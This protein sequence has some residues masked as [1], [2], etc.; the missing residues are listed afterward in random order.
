VRIANAG[1]VQPFLYSQ[2]SCQ[3]IKL[4]G[5][6]LG[7]FDDVSYEEVRL[8]LEPGNILVFYSDGIDDTTDS[9][10]VYF[11]SDRV[12][13]LVNKNFAL[14]SAEIAERILEAVDTFSGGAHAFDDRTLV[15]LKVL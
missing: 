11:G 3:Q 10:G 7:M 2:G 12:C 9:N 4:T 1:Q 14:N 5:F 8:I 15:V 13:D 6:P